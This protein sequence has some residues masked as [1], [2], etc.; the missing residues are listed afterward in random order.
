MIVRDSSFHHRDSKDPQGISQGWLQ[1]GFSLAKQ[2][3]NCVHILVCSNFSRGSFLL[4]FVFCD[5][6]NQTHHCRVQGGLEEQ[7]G[8][9][10][11]CW[12]PQAGTPW[13]LAVYKKCCINWEMKA[14][15]CYLLCTEHGG[16]ALW[17]STGASYKQ[18]WELGTAS[19]ILQHPRAH[20]HPRVPIS[21]L[22]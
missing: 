1:Q 14:S 11:Q 16:K 7:G 15:G 13:V 22:Q 12:D 2:V 4:H 10:L 5:H 3:G 18:V 21:H 20:P 17:A 9:F 6:G 19:L 8:F